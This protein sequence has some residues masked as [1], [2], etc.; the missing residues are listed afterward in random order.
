MGAALA[1]QTAAVEDA[2]VAG[3][4][5]RARAEADEL[6]AAVTAAIN[7]GDV[8][9]PLQEELLGAA[10]RLASLIPAPAEP[11][12]PPP[13]DEKG[14]GKGKG[15]GDKDKG[16]DGEKDEGKDGDEGDE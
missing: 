15:N 10:Q 2:L 8:P 12:A 13:A 5:A 16:E 4:V 14:K 7:R 9:P 11:H 1:A 3:Q 6:I